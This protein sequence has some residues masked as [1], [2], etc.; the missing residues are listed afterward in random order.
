MKIKVSDLIARFLKKKKINHVFVFTGGAA[1]HLI[2]SAKKYKINTIP[3]LHEQSCAMAADAY[4]RVSQNVG[5]TLSTSGPGATNLVT[6]VCGAYFDSVPVIYITGQVA[7]FRSKGKLKVRQIGFQETDCVSLFKSVT[8]Y[9]TKLKK[10][11][12]ILYELEKAYYLANSGRKGPVL[13]DIP[14]NLQREIVD[15]KKIKKYK[16]KNSKKIISKNQ[17]EK[18]KKLILNAKRPILIL[19][20]GIHLS[21]TYSDCKKFIKKYNIP[22]VKTWAVSHFVNKKNNLYNLGT[23]GTHGKRYSNF[24]VQNSDLII[25]LGSRLD[26]KATGTP[27]SSFARNAKKIMIDI[28]K[29]EITKFKNKFK[30]DLSMSV[31]L[32]IFFE[33][34]NKLK[35][36]F[37]NKNIFQWKKKILYWK[38]KYPLNYNKSFSKNDINPYYFFKV[39][40]KSMKDNSIIVSD[41]GCTIAWLCQTFNFKENQL[42]LHDFNNTAMGWALPAGIATK[43]LMKNKDVIIV[44]GDGSLSLNFQELSNFKNNNLNVKI[45]LLDNGGHSMIRQTQDTWLKSKY[46]ASSTSKDLPKIDFNFHASRFGFKTFNL[47][48]NLHLNKK[49]NNILKL[50]ERAFC[51]IKIDEKFGVEP[52]VLFGKP[53]EEMSPLLD[54]DILKK[55]MLI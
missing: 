38:D 49:I 2:D 51:T 26:T 13:L 23:W 11:S 43:L 25:S 52:Q 9:C 16:I 42:L 39:L 35:I 8:K 30:I 1:L 32:K 31:D 50:K 41:T 45:F 3:L 15:D 29:S 33:K 46:I 37:S 24:A 36:K 48:N 12:D 53:N 6:G 21:N 40:S 7:T 44:T 17:I 22:Y 27:P 19:G 14:D 20:W 28:D 34:I 54:Q 55:E 5:A 4:S 10:S 47:T 18:F